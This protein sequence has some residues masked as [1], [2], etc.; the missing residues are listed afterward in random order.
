MKQRRPPIN[1][2]QILREDYLE[3]LGLT[4][5]QL[6]A[7]IRCNIKMIHRIVN[8]QTPVTAKVAIKLGAAFRTTPEFWLDLQTEVDLYKAASSIGTLPRP[9][10][11]AT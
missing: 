7:H 6:A 9:L 11:T 10:I 4:Q 2:G 1:P 3:P 5:I 8:G